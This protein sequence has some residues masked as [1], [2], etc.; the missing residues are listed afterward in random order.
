MRSILV[1][2]LVVALAIG[3]AGGALALPMLLLGAHADSPT[4]FAHSLDPIA[5][6]PEGTVI[7]IPPGL[8][9][10]PAPRVTP[11]PKPRTTATRRR[12]R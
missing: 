4:R 6:E 12:A 1:R 2:A 8:V 5:P 11:K 10:E 3:G 9:G 7:R